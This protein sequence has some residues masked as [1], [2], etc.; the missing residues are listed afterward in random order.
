M[1][2]LLCDHRFIM[3]PFRFTLLR[4]S[5]KRE[6]FRDLREDQRLLVDF[7]TFPGTLIELLECCGVNTISECS[8]SPDDGEIRDNPLNL[9]E[10]HDSNSDVENRF[11]VENTELSK[12]DRRRHSSH[13]SIITVLT[14]DDV[15]LIP[16][17]DLPSVGLRTGHQTIQNEL[18][19]KLSENEEV[20]NQG[21]KQ[22]KGLGSRF[23]SGIQPTNSRRDEK[24]HLIK[25]P[26]QSSSLS[27]S[28]C[29]QNNNAV[30]IALLVCQCSNSVE[31]RP[32][33]IVFKPLVTETGFFNEGTS[34]R[35]NNNNSGV[36]QFSDGKRS[37]IKTAVLSFIEMNYFKELTHLSL[38]FTSANDNE[39]NQF[40][41]MRLSQWKVSCLERLN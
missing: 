36:E 27:Q 33:S 2:Q 40:L 1:S 18:N 37:R 17:S 3:T 7:D 11:V 25:R 9:Q 4:L 38:S 19:M 15:P 23:P 35:L 21:T 28:D 31:N 41:T 16:V 12:C 22:S 26:S 32:G 6:E 20:T 34:N 39:M 8:S 5:I 24:S 29:L 14:N 30:L 10:R 13:K